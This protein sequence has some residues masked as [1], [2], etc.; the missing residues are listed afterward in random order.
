[1]TENASVNTGLF[2]QVGTLGSSKPPPPPPRSLHY[3]VL[4]SPARDTAP[5]SSYRRLAMAANHEL[6]HLS[7]Y[8]A[9]GKLVC[10]ANPRRFP[11]TLI[12]RRSM[13][14]SASSPAP[15]GLWAQQ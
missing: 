7:P 3:S 8:R 6:D 10:H 13:A 5:D 14:S 11:R 15:K 4:G 9:D 1:M 12:A 2:D